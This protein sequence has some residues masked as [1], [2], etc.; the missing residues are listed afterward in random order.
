VRYAE[1]NA[2]IFRGYRV[3]NCPTQDAE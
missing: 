2:F 3:N 1:D